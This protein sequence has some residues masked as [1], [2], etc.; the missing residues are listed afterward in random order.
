MKVYVDV[1]DRDDYLYKIQGMD[2]LKFLDMGVARM[3][4]VLTTGK[5]RVDT[6]LLKGGFYT[7][8]LLKYW[9]I[10]PSIALSFCVEINR[11]EQYFFAD[12]LPD[13]SIILNNGLHISFNELLEYACCDSFSALFCYD[14]EE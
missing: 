14:M 8:R 11:K 2:A 3:L 6:V 10:S 4:A 5:L 7:E 9:F 1:L 12:K 13:G